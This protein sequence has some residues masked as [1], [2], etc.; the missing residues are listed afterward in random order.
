M[1][2][3]FTLLAISAALSAGAQT[4]SLGGMESWQTYFAGFLPPKQ[5]EKTTGW[6]CSDSIAV[7]FG[8]LIMQGQSFQKQLFKS[9]DKHNGSF[10]AKIVTFEQGNL[11]PVPAILTNADMQLDTS[12]QTFIKYSGGQPV[13]QRFN[14]VNAWIKYE[15]FGS[16]QGQMLAE[17]VIAGAGANGDDSVVGQGSLTIDATN[18]YEG[19]SMPI[20]YINSTVVP[21][22]IRVVFFSS[23]GT[24]EDSTAMYIDDV[25]IDLFTVGVNTINHNNEMVHV[26]PNPATSTI[27]ISSQ[28]NTPLQCEISNINGQLMKTASFTGKTSVDINDFTNGLYFFTVKNEHNNLIQKGKFTVAR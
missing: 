28:A 21:D 27:Y 20:D 23:F 12:S 7:T 2:K 5:L 16:D 26:Y 19:F 8:P 3:L 11:G 10:A 15:P 25:S 4:V 13:S 9:S 14:Y 18:G 24:P 6:H 22:H 1:K 17:A